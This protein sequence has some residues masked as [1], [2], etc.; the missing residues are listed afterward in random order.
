MAHYFPNTHDVGVHAGCLGSTISLSLCSPVAQ[1]RN[2]RLRDVFHPRSPGCSKAGRLAWPCILLTSQV[3]WDCL[4]SG[5]ARQQAGLASLCCGYQRQFLTPHP[6]S[7]GWE[8]LI[9]P[10]R[11]EEMGWRTGRRKQGCCQGARGRT[12]DLSQ[13]K[14]G[15]LGVALGGAGAAEEM[16]Q[17]PESP[18]SPVPPS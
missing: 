8:P 13:S 14:E 4:P 5:R 17:V 7:S 3:L 10:R 2:L 6:P 9:S 18:L 15:P 1:T 16:A 12:H 11:G